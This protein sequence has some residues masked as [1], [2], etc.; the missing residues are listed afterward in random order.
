[1]HANI[2]VVTE[3]TNET[4]AAMEVKTSQ[5][6]EFTFFQTNPSSKRQKKFVLLYFLAIMPTR[7]LNLGYR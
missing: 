5:Y 3:E 4:T 7:S 2:D 6:G 1:M